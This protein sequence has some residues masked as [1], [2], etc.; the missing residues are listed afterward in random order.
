M[1]QRRGAGHLLSQT[2][3]SPQSHESN[4]YANAYGNVATI[5]GSIIDAFPKWKVDPQL[6]L[7]V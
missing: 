2:F 5:L 4:V 1:S 6:K 3:K 7:G